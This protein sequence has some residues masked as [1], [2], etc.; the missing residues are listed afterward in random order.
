MIQSNVLPQTQMLGPGTMRHIQESG[1]LLYICK[2]YWYFLNLCLLHFIEKKNLKNM[3]HI[4][5][6]LFWNNINVMKSWKNN[7]KN[8]C[9]TSLEFISCYYFI[10]F[11]SL[12]SHLS[13]WTISEQVVSII[14]IFKQYFNKYFLLPEKTSQ[15]FSFFLL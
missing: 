10:A 12:L 13:S 15:S 5:N 4:F 11:V 7:S 14:R 6:F 1:K 3:G 9:I 8:S 2:D